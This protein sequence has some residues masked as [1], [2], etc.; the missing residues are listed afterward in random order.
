MKN[1]NFLR[2]CLQVIWLWFLTSEV[3]RCV[4]MEQVYAEVSFLPNSIDLSFFVQMHR[5]F[6]IY[7]AV[8]DN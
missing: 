5:T 6:E 1:Y 2:N 7:G 8:C 4:M 3:K